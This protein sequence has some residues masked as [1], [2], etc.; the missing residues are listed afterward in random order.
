M[1]LA[2]K[3]S[4]KEETMNLENETLLKSL[5]LS[6]EIQAHLNAN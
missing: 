1:I 2:Y 6:H 4:M 5:P 3:Y